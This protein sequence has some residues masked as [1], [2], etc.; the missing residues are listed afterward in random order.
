M[1]AWRRRWS[2]GEQSGF[3]TISRGTKNCTHQKMVVPWCYLG[4]NMLPP[5]K[6]TKVQTRDCAAKL[7]Y[8]SNH[9]GIL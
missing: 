3:T 6:Y 5:G 7:F 8:T 9:K 2:G 4:A 1:R